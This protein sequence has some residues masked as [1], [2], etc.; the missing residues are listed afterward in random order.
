M[1]KHSE[2]RWAVKIEWGNG[3]LDFV[4]PMHYQNRAQAQRIARTSFKERVGNG[5]D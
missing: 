3:K 5:R 2:I 4:Y 1:P